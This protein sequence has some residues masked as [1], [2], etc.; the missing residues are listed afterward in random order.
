[1]P[2]IGEAQCSYLGLETGFKTKLLVWFQ[3]STAKWMR[4]ELFWAITQRIVVWPCRR[5][6]TTYPSYLDGTDRFSRNV[7]KELPPYTP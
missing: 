3:A 6:G 4:S 2:R 7:G 1:M 5:F